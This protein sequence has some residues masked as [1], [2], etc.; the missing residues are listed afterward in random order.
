MGE[1]VPDLCI[2]FTQHR[3]CDRIG[4]RDHAHLARKRHVSNER[5]SAQYRA[6]PGICV[7][8][9]DRVQVCSQNLDLESFLR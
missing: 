7:A 9:P 3:M 5:S 8:G 6:L 1:T 4:T 2:S